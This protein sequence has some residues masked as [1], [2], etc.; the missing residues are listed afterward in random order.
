MLALGDAFV[1]G[2][3]TVMIF[4]VHINPF[5]FCFVVVRCPVFRCFP[6]DSKGFLNSKCGAEVRRLVTHTCT[7][8]GCDESQRCELTSNSNLKDVR[9][10]VLLNFLLADKVSH[11]HSVCIQSAAVA[12]DAAIRFMSPSKPFIQSS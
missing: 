4:L 11:Q 1:T 2:L 9:F 10:T 6:P 3:D 7:K 12:D 5:R 8:P